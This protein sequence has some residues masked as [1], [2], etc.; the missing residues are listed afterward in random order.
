[1]THT[2]QCYECPNDLCDGW[3]ESCP[4]VQ[5]K[6]EIYFEG[7]QCNRPLVSG[8]RCWLHERGYYE[9]ETVGLVE[10]RT[11]NLGQEKNHDQQS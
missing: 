11:E 2:P 1:M 6:C 4:A 9:N 7:W 5:P 8:N 3:S 10:H